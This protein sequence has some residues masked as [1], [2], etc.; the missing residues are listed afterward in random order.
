M[1]NLQNFIQPIKYNNHLPI[2]RDS[3]TDFAYLTQ[4]LY[5]K[6]SYNSRGMVRF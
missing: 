4:K 2:F 5:L 6:T 3:C 1:Q